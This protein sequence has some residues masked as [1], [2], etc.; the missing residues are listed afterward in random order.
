MLPNVESFYDPSTGTVSHI[1]YE[2]EG[3][4]SAIIDPVLDYDIVSCRISTKSLERMIRFI[5]R[6][7]LSVEWVLDTHVHA[8]HLSGAAELKR[9]IGGRTGIGQG[10]LDVQR[11]FGVTSEA[12]D[13]VG[14]DHLF[15]PD[16]AFRIGNLHARAIAT[17]GHTLS[18]SA[19]L[20]GDALFA[21]DSLFMPELGS[22]RCDFP[23]GDAQALYESIGRLLGLPDSTRLFVCH[24]YPQAGQP[25][26]VFTTIGEQRRHNIHLRDGVTESEFVALRTTRDQSLRAPALMSIVLPVN[27]RGGGLAE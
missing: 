27:L 1:V 6:C 24:D 16:E 3:S 10:L 9:R 23:G 19:Y 7:R 26:R 4:P 15:E 22:A 14:Y 21:G 5:E 11:I 8:D 25:A 12:G 2:C 18:D 17:P 20:V 13:Y